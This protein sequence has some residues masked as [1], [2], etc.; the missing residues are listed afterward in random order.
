M[1]LTPVQLY[2]LVKKSFPYEGDWHYARLEESAELRQVMPGVVPVDDVRASG[3][4][5]LQHVREMTR[6]FKH[7][8]T[9]KVVPEETK[10]WKSIPL[11]VVHELGADYTEVVRAEIERLIKDGTDNQLGGF[12]AGTA[13]Y[14]PPFLS[15]EFTGCYARMHRALAAH[16]RRSNTHT[17]DCGVDD[18]CVAHLNAHYWGLAGWIDNLYAAW[19]KRNNQLADQ[20]PV[21]PTGI[22]GVRVSDRNKFAELSVCGSFLPLAKRPKVWLSLA[23]WRAELA[24]RRSA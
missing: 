17:E 7:L 8:A 3:R 10:P 24:R 11:F 21:P 1:K 18:P 16:D 4:Q 2:D 5:F 20:S 9:N 15:E 14:A 23:E 19:Q 6:V 12:I 22:M 13:A